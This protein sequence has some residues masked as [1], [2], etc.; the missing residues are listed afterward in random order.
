MN[1]L[2]SLETILIIYIIVVNM[3]G[4]IAIIMAEYAPRKVSDIIFYI[5]FGVAIPITLPMVLYLITF[6]KLKRI[7]RKS[8]Y[9]EELEKEISKCIK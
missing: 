4:V 9:D 5:F 3:L 8:I 6:D 7:K 1:N 2:T